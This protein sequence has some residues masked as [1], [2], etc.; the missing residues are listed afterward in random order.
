MSSTA[1]AM[2]S[3]DVGYGAASNDYLRQIVATVPP[4][5]TALSQSPV[6][7]LTPC[8]ALPVLSQTPYLHSQPGTD[9]GVPVL[10]FWSKLGRTSIPHTHPGTDLVVAPAPGCSQLSE[11]R[12]P[13]LH[14]SRATCRARVH[15][16]GSARP[17]EGRLQGLPP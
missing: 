15:S 11:T 12:R 4:Q 6:S 10:V 16:C 9:V 17:R 5:V 8:T 13:A 2:S 1:Y 14:G 7:V 3:T